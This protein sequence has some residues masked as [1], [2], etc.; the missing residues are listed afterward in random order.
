M[1]CGGLADRAHGPVGA[2]PLSRGMGEHRGEPNKTRL[3][4]R[5]GLQGRDLMLAQ[6]LADDGRACSTARHNGTFGR[7]P[8]ETVTGWW[9]SASSPGLV[10]SACALASAAAMVPI[11]SARAY[12]AWSTSSSTWLRASKL[13]RP[14]ISIVC[15]GHRGPH[16]LP[17]P[18][19]ASGPWSSALART[20]PFSGR[21]RP[22]AGA[23]AKHASK[24]VA[25]EFDPLI[26]IDLHRLDPGSRQAQR[27]TGEGARRFRHC[28]AAELLLGS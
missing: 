21:E 22:K 20:L 24:L 10:S 27:R 16:L 3:I 18:P 6:R 28:S 4:D 26:S 1:W 14:R 7:S 9:R 15:P 17:W 8:S 23:P 2:D 19:G 5:R 25:Q 12:G 11:G 13:P